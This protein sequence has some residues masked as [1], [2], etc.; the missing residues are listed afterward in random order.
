MI[1]PDYSQFAGCS[2]VEA[3]CLALEGLPFDRPEA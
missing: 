3:H 1:R 2:E